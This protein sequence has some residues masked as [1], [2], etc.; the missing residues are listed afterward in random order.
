MKNAF[1]ISLIINIVMILV[2]GYVIFTKG[3][4]EYLKAKFNIQSKIQLKQNY[5]PYY[6]AKK[7]IFEIMPNDTSEIIFFGSSITMDCD[8]NEL[9]KK[10][11]IKNRGLSGDKIEGMTNRLSEVIECQPKIIFLEAGVNDLQQKR[12]LKQI[13]NDYEQLV[14]S[15]REKSPQTIL[16]IQSILPT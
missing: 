6:K 2:C 13:L 9:F 10:N 15:I 8:W 3:G 4:I 12:A 1:A 11:N 5:S 16:Y 14:I 7:S